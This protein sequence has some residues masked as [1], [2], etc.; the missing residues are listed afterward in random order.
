LVTSNSDITRVIENT[1]DLI[2][3]EKASK[4]KPQRQKYQLSPAFETKE[5]RGHTR[6]IST[7]ASWREGFS[8]DIH[9]YKKCG[10][11]DTDAESTNNDEEQ[12]ASC[13]LV[14]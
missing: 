3:K 4:F 8:E 10:R 13:S 14:S 6:A 7:I 12:F 2:T 9:M 1:K 11:H 5:H